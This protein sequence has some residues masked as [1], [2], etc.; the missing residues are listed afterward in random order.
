MATI[1][2]EGDDIQKAI[3]WISSNLQDNP[4]QPISKLIEKA[5]L[6]YDLS[7]M[8]TEFLSNFFRKKS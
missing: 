2:P 1:M 3:K 7:P 5:A 6:Q 4:N 8:N